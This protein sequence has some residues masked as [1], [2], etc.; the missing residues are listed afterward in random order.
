MLP[1][2]QRG[3][4]E[5]LLSRRRFAGLV[6]AS[7]LLSACTGSTSS[8]SDLLST[9]PK[10]GGPPQG[11]TEI[12]AGRV[13]VGLILPLSA[14]GNA[15]LAAASM[16]NGAEMALAEFNSQDLQLLV[17]DDAG[18]APG[19]QQAGQQVLDEGAELILGMPF[20]YVEQASLGANWDILVGGM[21]KVYGPTPPGPVWKPAPQRS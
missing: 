11:G 10:P 2:P 7:S 17:K 9:S 20:P 19:A 4:S 8:L 18:S 5:A 13:K 21:V 15:G 12:G 3:T 16:R 6:A 1:V 14:G